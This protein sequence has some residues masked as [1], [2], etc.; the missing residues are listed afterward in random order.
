M[1]PKEQLKFAV[2]LEYDETL[3]LIFE[4]NPNQF[5]LFEKNAFENAFLTCYFGTA[6]GQLYNS[7]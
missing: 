3:S 7:N 6:V 4:V 5:A 1:F 2:R